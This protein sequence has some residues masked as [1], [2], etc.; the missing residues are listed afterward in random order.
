MS[1]KT[2]E[3]TAGLSRRSFIKGAGTLAAAS[4]FGG[5]AP[6][7]MSSE[8]KVLRYLGTAVNQDGRSSSL[9]APNGPSQQEVIRT[10]LRNADV[11]P[12][13]VDYVECHGTGTALGDPIEVASIS[14]AILS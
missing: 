7:V 13:D 8:K 4:M 2:Q 14:A 1:K 10:A 12:L 3:N 11:T 6:Y 9:T 5:V